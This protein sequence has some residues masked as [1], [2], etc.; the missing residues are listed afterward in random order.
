MTVA[1]SLS[2]R[3]KTERASGNWPGTVSFQ[4]GNRVHKQ[5][6]AVPVFA[7]RLP[8]RKRYAQ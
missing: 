2:T 8:Q 4:P 3:Y 7:Y 6:S 5:E 1:D